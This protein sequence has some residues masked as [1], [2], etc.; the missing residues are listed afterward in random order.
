MGQ[1][2]NSREP[3]DK[4]RTVISN[5]RQI[6]HR[7]KR[8]RRL[9]RKNMLCGSRERWRKRND[10]PGVYWRLESVMIK[11]QKNM[12]VK[13]KYCDDLQAVEKGYRVCERK[14]ASKNSN[15][16]YFYLLFSPS[17]DN[18]KI[19]GSE[20]VPGRKKQD[21]KDMDFYEDYRGYY[22]RGSQRSSGRPF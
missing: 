8:L 9:K 18:I 6:I 2:L 17:Q 14:K 15:L 20:Q 7:K 13:Q 22:L 4:Y 3:Y 19:Y 21:G 5:R 10:I 16:Y 11:K 1:F 12:P